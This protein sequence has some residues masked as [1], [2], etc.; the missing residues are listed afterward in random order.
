MRFMAVVIASRAPPWQSLRDLPL[1]RRFGRTQLMRHAAALR[2]TALLAALLALAACDRPGSAA[3]TDKAATAAAGPQAPALPARPAPPAWAPGLLTA[4]MPAALPNA[5]P[6]EGG[7]D[8]LGDRYADAVQVLG[9][10]WNTKAQ[11][12]VTR[13]VAV[14]RKGRF[15]GFGE[16]GLERPTV[17]GETSKV[18]YQG[19]GWSLVTGAPAKNGVR[20]YGVDLDAKAACL[21]GEIVPQ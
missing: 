18:T 8:G 7:V 3:G 9:W 10:A 16:G 14:N 6:C 17:P 1:V 11:A 19:A 5:L 15:V 4:E 13:V 12:P 20:I 21:L 2:T